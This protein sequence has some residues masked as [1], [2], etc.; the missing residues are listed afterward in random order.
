MALRFETGK[1]DDDRQKKFQTTAAVSDTSVVQKVDGVIEKALENEAS[2]VHFEPTP[3]EVVV[4]ARIGGAL[5]QIEAFPISLLGK[6]ANRIKI[7]GAMDITKSKLPQSGFFKVVTDTVKIDIIAYTFPTI[8]GEKAVLQIQYKKGVTHTLDDLG[9]IPSMLD[10]LKENLKRTNGLV[11]AAGPPG[12]GKNTTLYASLQFLSTPKKNIA[13]FEPTV[14]YELPGVTQGKPDE[15]AEFSFE[16]G[17]R[18][19]INTGPDVLL[20]GEV[21]SPEVAKAVVQAAFEKRIVLARMSAN[22]SVNALQNLIDMGIQPFLVSSAVNAIVAQRL[23]RK[24]CEG[25]KEE[26][27]PPNQLMQEL[28]LKPGIQFFRGKGCAQCGQTGYSGL[29]GLFELLDMRDELREMIIARESVR[30]IQEKALQLGMVLLKKDGIYKACKG[31]TSIEEV[32]N[33]V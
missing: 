25:C 24:L 17:V 14:K 11:I 5:Q 4:R 22:G 10:K 20:I 13:T 9:M 32:L 27:T 15:K 21:Q 31:L 3:E 28:G 33:A 30:R 8:R 29:L 26:Y 19:I 18:G 2:D 12:N 16:E 6:I 1:K 7:L 23:V